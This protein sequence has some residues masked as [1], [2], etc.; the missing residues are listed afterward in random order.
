[1]T[2]N[3][4]GSRTTILQRFTVGITKFSPVFLVI[5]FT[6]VMGL[7]R[8]RFLSIANLLTVASQ[9]IPM[10]LIA[11][12]Q[13]L[14][15]ISAGIDLS[16][17][18]G[19][20]IVSI[21]IGVVYSITDSIVLALCLGLIS[22]LF[23]GLLNATLIVKMKLPAF[24]VTLG[25]MAI[26]DGAVFLVMGTLKKVAF[27]DHPIF[28]F[29]GYGEIGKIPISFLIM[30]VIYLIVF[31]IYKYHRFGTYLIAIGSDESGARLAG[32]NV[33]RIRFVV[34]LLSG[35]FMSIAGIFMVARLPIVQPIS[36]GTNTLLLNSIAAAVIGGTSLL[37]GKGT[38]QGTF[39]GVIFMGLVGN[40]L[41]MLNVDPNHQM[42]YS[43]LII[44]SAILFDVFI[45]SGKIIYR[46]SLEK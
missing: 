29:L 22:G 1:M 20:A 28:S 11:L 12:G 2:I 37:G 31:I 46:L 4:A 21:V 7:L 45:N 25:T 42:M 34:Y 38:I 26:I 24:I 13:T 23:L 40:A 33:E 18:Q 32:I 9:I 30:S 43:G 14:V 39:V 17:S 15:L 41:N 8:Q 35:L 3:R 5:V 6:I 19:I 36:A 27:I 16:T 10:G 44:L